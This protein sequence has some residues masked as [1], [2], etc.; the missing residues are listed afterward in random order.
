MHENV[1]KLRNKVSLKN[2][3]NVGVHARIDQL[4]SKVITNASK[5]NNTTD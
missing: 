5:I 2:S 4:N 3:L 1:I